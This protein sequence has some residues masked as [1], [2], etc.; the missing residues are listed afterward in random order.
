MLLIPFSQCTLLLVYCC[1]CPLSTPQ[2]VSTVDELLNLLIKCCCPVRTWVER[3]CEISVATVAAAVGG[4]GQLSMCSSAGLPARSNRAWVVWRSSAVTT[5]P[6][7]VWDGQTDRQTTDREGRAHT[8]TLASATAKMKGAGCP[9]STD[10][11]C[12]AQ[13][14][15][16]DYT[17]RGRQADTIDSG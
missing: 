16:K 9:L 14:A 13:W 3:L 7:Q 2:T 10:T 12:A 11:H 1:R 6:R 15:G 4:L 8:Y 5:T 17:N